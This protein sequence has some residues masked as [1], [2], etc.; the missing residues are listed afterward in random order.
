LV[1][2]LGPGALQISG[3]CRARTLLRPITGT[4]DFRRPPQYI[5]VPAVEFHRERG[6]PSRQPCE[7]AGIRTI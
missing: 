1:E 5:S 6:I 3:V 7:V 4:L 2:I